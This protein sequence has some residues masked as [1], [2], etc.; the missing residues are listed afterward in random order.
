MKTSQRSHRNPWTLPEKWCETASYGRTSRTPEG[1]LPVSRAGCSQVTIPAMSG[2]APDH[3]GEPLILAHPEPRGEPMVPA[4]PAQLTPRGLLFSSPLPLPLAT[5]DLCSSP[6][7][8]AGRK[9]PFRAGGTGYSRGLRCE[10]QPHYSPIY[11]VPFGRRDAQPQDFA[12][13]NISPAAG[14]G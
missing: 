1:A 13:P 2:I 4:S 3:S 7:R 11:E 14:F 12:C 5:F 8:T 9:L 10:L 6:A